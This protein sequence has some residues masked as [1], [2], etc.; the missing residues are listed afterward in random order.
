MTGIRIEEIEIAAFLHDFDQFCSANG[1]QS[2]SDELLTVVPK[3]VTPDNVR[4][5]MDGT[6]S[7]AWILKRADRICLGNDG[8]LEST[9]TALQ[10]II[11]SVAVKGRQGI[12]ASL[13]LCEKTAWCCLPDQQKS[14]RTMAEL[15]AGLLADIH[16]LARWKDFFPF[17]CAM[18]SMFEHY[19]STV[20]SVSSGVSLYQRAKTLVAVASSIFSYCQTHDVDEAT[21]DEAKAFV[22][23]SGDATGIQKYIFDVKSYRHSAKLIRAK[24]FQ[25]WIQSFLIA[26]NICARLGLTNANI[27]T[28]S[29]GKFLLLVP[30]LPKLQPELAEVRRQVDCFCIE[31]Y[32][33]EIAYVISHGVECSERDLDNENASSIQRLIRS[34]CADAKQK[35][36]QAGIFERESGPVLEEQYEALSR[37]GSLCAACECNPAAEGNEFCLE[38][39]Y[40]VELGRKLSL[41][42]SYIYLDF[43]I[44]ESLTST[45]RIMARPGDNARFQEY[46][47]S[48]YEPG[49]A[50][51]S[52]PY[53]VPM[54]EDGDV[55]TFENMA[56]KAKGV[57]RL[58]MFKAD[59][60]YL[61]YIFSSSLNK[62]WS[63]S[64]YA[65]LSAWF[66]FFFSETL[67]THIQEDYP[68]LY[69][70]FSGGD[71]VCVIGPWNEILSFSVSINA[72]FRW[73]TADNESITLS[74][75]VVLFNHHAPIPG[76]ADRAEEALEE[77]KDQ[78]QKNS[79]TLFSRTVGWSQ[80][81]Q[82]ISDAERLQNLNKLGKS[83]FLYRLLSYS[84][85][86]YEVENKPLGPEN[87]SK[88]L[89]MS[90]YRYALKRY[91]IKGSSCEDL[92]IQ[93]RDAAKMKN[94][95]IAASIALYLNR[96]GNE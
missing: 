22:L 35:K 4:A 32:C 23:L 27:I 13:P 77:S 2:L 79:V 26:G 33:G 6:A 58:A 83:G 46:T 39:D 43:S 7:E 74:A 11:A 93:Y 71:D 84:D 80:L 66:Q 86:A 30:N 72:L 44:I 61:G 19:M 34:D 40:L 50:R 92:L 57:E 94:A 16:E 15:H 81:E 29:G 24:S 10:S 54:S 53:Y 49:R 85:N 31:S 20:P 41:Q 55:L 56:K 65:S 48:R 73:F 1:F 14:V 82:A 59:V 37:S 18:D 95:R 69:V 9:P 96:G 67:V 88:A 64:R 8:R 21:F 89:W 91:N 12:N 63:L 70:V 36:L 25:I 60:D 45:V 17:F 75:G 5:L 47:I 42:G 68:N 38:C 51:L 3:C 87:I 28:F 78:P 76:V 62:R 90:H 52:M